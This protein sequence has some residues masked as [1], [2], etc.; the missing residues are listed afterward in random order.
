MKRNQNKKHKAN[1]RKP[2]VPRT[3]VRAPRTTEEL[4]ARPKRFQE[5]WNR[6]VQVPAEMRSGLT[7]RHASRQLGVRPSL[8]IQLAGSAFKKKRNGRYEVKPTDKLLRVLVV[9]S[10]KGLREIA[11]RDSREASLIGQYWSAVE[12]YLVTGDD[13]AFRK[14]PRKKVKGITGK[15]VR[16]LT[17]LAELRRQ[18]SAGVLQ[19][20]SLYGR[21]A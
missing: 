1:S 21:N 14:L 20:E 10:R 8:V 12:K 4:F 9:P 18:G 19:F 2:S 15:S 17:N 13:S 6:I 7:L 16:L 5:Q 11:V 3:N